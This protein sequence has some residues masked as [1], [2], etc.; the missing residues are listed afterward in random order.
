[1]QVMRWMPCV[2]LLTTPVAV[3][4]AGGEFDALSPD[5]CEDVVKQAGR[6][7]DQVNASQDLPPERFKENRPSRAA[8]SPIGKVREFG[9]EDRAG[10]SYLLHVDKPGLP[11]VV[12]VYYPDCS[13]LCM[14]VSVTDPSG[15]A[16]QLLVHT[17]GEHPTS[18][19]EHFVDVVCFPTTNDPALALLNYLP[20]RTAVVSRVEVY[21]LPELP[22]A[23][24]VSRLTGA[25]TSASTRSIR[26]CCCATSGRAI[27]TSSP[28]TWACGRR[29]WSAC[30]PTCSSRGRICWSAPRTSTTGA[31]PRP[32]S[33]GAST[34]TGRGRS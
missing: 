34:W 23:Q 1:M 24:L 3:G 33:S 4:A 22:A 26:R 8:D 28:K 11:H 7:V 15:P 14:K 27:P 10:I 16:W 18:E 6:L 31:P 17:G 29:R 30:A 20:S 9:P 13:E 12:R 2:L 21:E 5:N 19:R 32:R 25:A